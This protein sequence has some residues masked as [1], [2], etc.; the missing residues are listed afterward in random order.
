M[1]H[2]KAPRCDGL[3]C[4]APRQ[5]T[6]QRAE[7][8]LFFLKNP[9]SDRSVLRLQRCHLWHYQGMKPFMKFSGRR[10]DLFMVAMFQ[11]I[12]SVCIVMVCTD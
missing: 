10:I 12:M 3:S 4:P 8:T 1:P 6:Y 9:E 7:N 2:V 5:N 11:R